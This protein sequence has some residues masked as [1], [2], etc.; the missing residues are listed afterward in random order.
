M[1]QIGNIHIGK[2]DT[3]TQPKVDIVEASILSQQ[4]YYRYL[5]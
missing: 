4:L 1:V 2:A 3:A 5:S